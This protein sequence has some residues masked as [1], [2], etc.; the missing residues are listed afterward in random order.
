MFVTSSK[1]K[2]TNSF[3]KEV[4][5]KTD[6]KRAMAVGGHTA[7]AVRRDIVVAGACHKG[8]MQYIWL[9]W[10]ENEKGP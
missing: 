8:S 1:K 2:P 7:S 9:N 4:G 5:V 3:R 6:P 10:A